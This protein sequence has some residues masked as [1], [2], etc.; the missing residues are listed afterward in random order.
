MS[1]TFFSLGFSFGEVSKISDVCRVWYEEHFIFDITHSQVDVETKFQPRGC[2]TTKNVEEHCIAVQ[3][4][5]AV[6]RQ[7]LM[8]RDSPRNL[9]IAVS[10]QCSPCMC[11]SRLSRARK[12]LLLC[13]LDFPIANLF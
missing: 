6:Q 8:P 2:T 4:T 9:I 13:F 11:R 1:P 5:R 7:K 12:L 3:L 10:K